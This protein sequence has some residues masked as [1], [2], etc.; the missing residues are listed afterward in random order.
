MSRPRKTTPRQSAHIGRLVGGVNG[1]PVVN[2]SGAAS[3]ANET[4]TAEGSRGA[5]VAAR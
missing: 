2:A 3:A 4:L 1:A 5:V